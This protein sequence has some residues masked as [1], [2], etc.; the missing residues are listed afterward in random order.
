MSNDEVLRKEGR[1][2][3][4]GWFLLTHKNR[5]SNNRT[6]NN[7]SKQESKEFKSEIAY[8]VLRYT[9]LYTLTPIGIKGVRKGCIECVY[10]EFHSSSISGWIPKCSFQCEK[11]RRS[12]FKQFQG[13]VF[14]QHRSKREQKTIV[15]IPILVFGPHS[16]RS[17]GWGGI[18]KQGPLSSYQLR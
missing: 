11:R 8:A 14:V 9:Q 4:R 15:Q 17:G 13:G 5:K 7:D 6:S 12:L 2:D 10:V 3:R 18:N 16:L 1:G